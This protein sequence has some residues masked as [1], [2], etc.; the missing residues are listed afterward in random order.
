MV[1]YPL[2]D[3]AVVEKGRSLVEFL[4]STD[5]RVEAAILEINDDRELRLIIATPLVHEYGRLPIYDK[6]QT[7]VLGQPANLRELVDA[8]DLRSP[9]EGI[10]TILD[11]ARGSGRLPLNRWIEGEMHNGFWLEGLYIYFF[12]P[13]TFIRPTNP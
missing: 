6:L 11:Q 1:K 5:L 3:A 2:V 13:K 4:R 9:S 7:L 10:I 8:V 12:D